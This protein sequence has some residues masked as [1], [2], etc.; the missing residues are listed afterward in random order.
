MEAYSKFDLKRINPFLSIATIIFILTT[1]RLTGLCMQ[2]GF[3]V[4]I[5]MTGMTER[6]FESVSDVYRVTSN[7][8]ARLISYLPDLTI[9]N[10]C[11]AV[12]VAAAIFYLHR[13]LLHPFKQV[14]NLGDVGYITDG[15]NKKEVANEIRKRRRAGDVPPV[16]PNGW[17]SLLRSRELKT[18]EVKYV[19]ALGKG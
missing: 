14:R 16:Y 5:S 11:I 17:F 6:F 13:L 10:L 12:L 7:S 1:F 2:S 15:R 4:A 19:S 9:L 8:S 18:G 3:S